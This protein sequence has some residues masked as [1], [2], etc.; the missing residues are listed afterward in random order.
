[1]SKMKRLAIGKGQHPGVRLNTIGVK[2]RKNILHTAAFFF[3]QR[4]Y[5]NFIPGDHPVI[6]YR[7]GITGLPFQSQRKPFF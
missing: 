1:M 7:P 2:T 5:G 4:L 6:P 3:K